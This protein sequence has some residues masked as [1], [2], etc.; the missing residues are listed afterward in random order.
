MRSET[1]TSA[2]SWLLRPLGLGVALVAAKVMMLGA[3]PDLELTHPMVWAGLLHDHLLVVVLFLFLNLF[4]V[5]RTRS[6]G[7]ESE[8]VAHRALWFLHGLAL[9]WVAASVPIAAGLGAPSSIIEL[10]QA[11]GV[12]ALILDNLDLR[13]SFASLAVFSLGLASPVAL[14]R[15]PRSRLLLMSGLFG[16]FVAIAGPLGREA[17][18]LKGLERDPFAIVIQ[19]IWQGIEAL[20]G[21]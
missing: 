3:H 5:L 11:G 12:Q 7:P 16:A 6:A 1:L 17:H 8:A 14:R 13:T 20:G 4:F 19:S 15:A 9:L 10:R 2:P 21:S 18:D